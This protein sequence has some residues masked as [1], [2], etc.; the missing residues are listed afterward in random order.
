MKV[1]SLHLQVFLIQLCRIRP[2]GVGASHLNINTEKRNLSHKNMLELNQ[3]RAPTM[4]QRLA[5][6]KG[7]GART[8]YVNLKALVM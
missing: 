5:S 8:V 1:R 3:E 7:F 4:L 2:R 6:L